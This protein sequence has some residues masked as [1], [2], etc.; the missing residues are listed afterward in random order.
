[1][2]VYNSRCVRI[3]R[4]ARL[5]ASA[6]IAG[7]A[8]PPCS[9]RAVSAHAKRDNAAQGAQLCVEC[10]AILYTTYICIWSYNCIY[11]VHKVLVLL[12]HVCQRSHPLSHSLSLSL[13][14]FCEHAN[15]RHSGVQNRM[16]CITYTAALCIGTAAARRQRRT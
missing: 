7:H 9:A 1:M 5:C 13:M 15:P 6:R 3:A 12:R 11:V 16:C 10:G 14:R 2:Y 4:G 8:L